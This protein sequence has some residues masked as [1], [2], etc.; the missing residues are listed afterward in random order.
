MCRY[1][2]LTSIIFA[3]ILHEHITVLRVIHYNFSDRKYRLFGGLL[4]VLEEVE[5]RGRPQSTSDGTH[6]ILV[7]V[8]RPS[9]WT[10][11]IRAL[12][13]S[14]SCGQVPR[15]WGRACT[16]HLLGETEVVWNDRSVESY[17]L[18]S[19]VDKRDCSSPHSAGRNVG[20]ASAIPLKARNM[21]ASM[22]ADS[23]SSPPSVYIK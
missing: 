19:P 11:K 18:K 6:E 13:A 16:D 20:A 22:Q 4:N 5:K 15:G 10:L 7:T 8:N 9:P 23:S 17:K 14:Q 12:A 3:C 2:F 1:Q 21:N